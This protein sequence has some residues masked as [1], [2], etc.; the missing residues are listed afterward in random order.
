MIILYVIFRLGVNLVLEW[1]IVIYKER[2][3][4]EERVDILGNKGIIILWSDI[5][6]N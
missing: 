1:F 4:Y 2:D 3:E 6:R 5:R